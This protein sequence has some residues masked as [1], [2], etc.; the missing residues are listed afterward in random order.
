MK[1]LTRTQ[2]LVKAQE[3]VGLLEQPDLPANLRESALARAQAY[4]ALAQALSADPPESD[5]PVTHDQLLRHVEAVD[6][7]LAGFRREVAQAKVEAAGEAD[8]R[9]S[10][11]EQ[12]VMLAVEQ[13]LQPLAAL[14]ADH[15]L[16]VAAYDMRPSIDEY[17]RQ[18]E[19][20]APAESDDDA[21]VG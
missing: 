4:S 9:M 5:A 1:N 11:F 13:K 10:D 3:A 7:V 19:E 12:R 18:S 20:T 14:Q 21:P 16:I 15:D 6:D 2:A 8:E 17:L